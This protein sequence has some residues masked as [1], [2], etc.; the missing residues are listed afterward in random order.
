MN[1]PRR[2]P[3]TESQS[4][5]LGYFALGA[6]LV[7]LGCLLGLTGCGYAKHKDPPTY[8][9]SSAAA[10]NEAARLHARDAHGTLLQV[11][12]PEGS[13][14]PLIHQ[15]DWLVMVPTPLGD[16]LLGKV[17][18]YH[19]DW[20]PSSTVTHRLVAKDRY[21]Y[22]ASGDHNAHSEPEYRVTAANYVGEIIAIYR[23]DPHQ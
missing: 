15:W 21:G 5:L 16:D 9:E 4:N 3:L 18:T 19:A 11:V 8:F 14:Q 7:G 22:I 23:E 1:P 12:N 20:F 6:F 17:V 2:H 10:A 13:M